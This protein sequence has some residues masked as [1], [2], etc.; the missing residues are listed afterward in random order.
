MGVELVV[1]A[2]AAAGTA[3]T[4]VLSPWL[5][6]RL[7]TE[8]NSES[9]RLR[10]IIITDGHVP[11]AFDTD[12]ADRGPVEGRNDPPVAGA[13]TVD[14]D[15]FAELLIEYYAWGLTQARRSTAL[16][17]TCSA[18]GILV[19]LGGVTLAIWKAETTGDLY[20]SAVTSASGMVS[21]VIGHLA[22]RRAD[23]A[24]DHMRVQTE[25]LRA[26]MQ[27]ERETE[28]AIRLHREVED[29]GLRAQ[30]QAALILKLADAKIPNVPSYVQ[31]EKESS[32]TAPRVVE[33]RNG[34]APA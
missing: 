6:K 16:S 29:H 18:L 1:A 23:K 17:L 28:A 8:A 15:K 20:A 25:S 7:R 24:M 10:S 22:H 21:T 4:G 5:A 12:D 34:S 13:Q 32:P 9:A 2:I 27:R 33:S 31:P 11:R 3:V 19:L 26:D 14:D 30:L